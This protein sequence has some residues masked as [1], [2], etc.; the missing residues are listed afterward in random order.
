M[1]RRP[2]SWTDAE[3]QCR[4]RGLQFTPLRR[5]IFAELATAGKPLGAYDLVERLGQ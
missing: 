4:A 5:R 1:V 2:T 3:A